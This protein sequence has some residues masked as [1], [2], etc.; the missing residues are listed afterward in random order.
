MSLYK[1]PGSEVWWAA[2]SHPGQKRLRFSTGEYDREAAQRVHDERKAALWKQAPALKGRTWGSA[3][4][5]W[6]DQA[7]RSYTEL[8][9][10]RKFN[11][12]YS[13]RLLTAVT[14]E[15]IDEALTKFCTS[16]ATYTRHRARVSHVLKLSD[17][18]IK[19]E[20]R[21][22]GKKKPRKWLTPP[23]WVK[24]YA[25]L[26]SH[27]KPMAEFA[28][29]TGLRQA[30]VLGLTWSRVDLGRKVVWVEAEDAK[31]AEGI[32][33]PLSTGA[34]HV[35]KGQQGQH[36]EFVF[37]Y[38]GR[39]IK[40]IKTAFIAAC[41]RSGCGHISAEG[42]YTGFT[43]HGFRHTWATWHVQHGTPLDV[44]QKLGAWKDERMVQNYAHHSPGYL[45]QFA[46][47]ARNKKTL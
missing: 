10:I 35:L 32:A 41:V 26:P 37:T 13:D 12:Y 33:V 31:G 45:A 24:L 1:Q 22:A 3:V 8:L 46:D 21:K 27:M 5:K 17:V 9:G 36:P 2:I 38:R 47:N 19:L 40:E 28:L 18:T 11:R 6:L 30:N 23:Q 7:P 43:W 20:T 42:R 4:N 44:L 25:E 16:A 14:P 29:E 15:S 39:P 34:I